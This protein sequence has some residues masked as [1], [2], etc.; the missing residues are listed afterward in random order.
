[1]FEGYMWAIEVDDMHGFIYW[2]ESGQIKR[3][4]LD[5]SSTKVIV[6]GGKSDV[7]RATSH[8]SCF[9][10]LRL[11][12]ILSFSFGICNIVTL[13]SIRILF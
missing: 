9:I 8:H 6:T 7:T 11:L 10:C 4:T 13:H 12:F 1:M 2:G 5:G 3:T